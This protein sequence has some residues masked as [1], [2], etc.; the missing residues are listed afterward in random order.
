MWWQNLKKNIFFENKQSFYWSAIG[1]FSFPHGIALSIRAPRNSS[2]LIRTSFGSYT[3]T[4]KEGKRPLYPYMFSLLVLF[5]I[6]FHPN[7][8]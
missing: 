7:L 5:L 3:V 6:W 2:V 8:D 1:F 4:K